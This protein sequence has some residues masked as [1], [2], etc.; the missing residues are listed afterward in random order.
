MSFRNYKVEIFILQDSTNFIH[1][2]WYFNNLK[3]STKAPSTEHEVQTQDV[4]LYKPSKS[5]LYSLISQ[6]SFKDRTISSRDTSVS[7]M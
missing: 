6:Q 2:L 5:P 7:I 1:D 3:D 4:T